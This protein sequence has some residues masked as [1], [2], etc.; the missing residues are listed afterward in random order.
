MSIHLQRRQN[1]ILSNMTKKGA[2]YE[3][4]Y[5]RNLA[6]RT[7]DP[8]FSINDAVTQILDESKERSEVEIAMDQFFLDNLPEKYTQSNHAVLERVVCNLKNLDKDLGTRG[9]RNSA[10]KRVSTERIKT[11]I[12]HKIRER[13]FT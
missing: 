4:S 9:K 13:N 11:K 1:K 8:V 10:F 3:N 2:R 7:D 5:T 12:V 6:E